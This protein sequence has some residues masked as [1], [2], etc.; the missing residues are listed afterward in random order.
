[1]YF[2]GPT[3]Y[4]FLSAMSDKPV[5]KAGGVLSPDGFVSN[6]A[7]VWSSL[8][9]MIPF[10]LS[11]FYSP[12]VHSIAIGFSMMWSFLYHLSGQKEF[13]QLDVACATLLTT[14][15]MY[16]IANATASVHP[17]DPRIVMAT[18]FGAGSLALLFTSGFAS[19][20]DQDKPP[21]DTIPH[22]ETYHSVWHLTGVIATLFVISLSGHFN[23]SWTTT[24]IDLLKQSAKNTSVPWMV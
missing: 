20:S 23:A 12:F 18:L 4:V 22:Y 19:V 21:Q 24:T 13:E 15:N 6:W 7:L 1:M 5:E 10:V 17:F 9:M 16:L 8:T 3:T 11:L 14:V 2:L